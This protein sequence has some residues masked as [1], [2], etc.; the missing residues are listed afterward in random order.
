MSDQRKTSESTG[1]EERPPQGIFGAATLKDLLDGVILN[2]DQ[3]ERLARLHSEE[4]NSE[5]LDSEGLES[6]RLA[7]ITE[8]GSAN[9]SVAKDASTGESGSVEMSIDESI[10]VT[11]ELSAMIVEHVLPNELDWPTVMRYL[12]YGSGDNGKWQED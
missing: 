3:L 7:T 8:G 2:A 12:E 9:E 10:E 1:T 4:V 6:D 5:R 11:P